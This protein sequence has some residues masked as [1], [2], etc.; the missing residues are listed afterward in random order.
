MSYSDKASLYYVL[1]EDYPEYLDN[2]LMTKFK[3]ESTYAEEHFSLEKEKWEWLGDFIPHK[4][5]DI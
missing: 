2:S 1:A 3:E 4:M 5:E